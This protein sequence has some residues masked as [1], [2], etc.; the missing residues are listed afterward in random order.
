MDAAFIKDCKGFSTCLLSMRVTHI[1]RNGNRSAKLLI[2][3]QKQD[4]CV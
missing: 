4:V 2:I 3:Q 1:G